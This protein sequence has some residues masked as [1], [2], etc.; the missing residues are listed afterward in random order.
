MERTEG[1]RENRT[2]PKPRGVD[3]V[4]DKAQLLAGRYGT[5]EMCDIWGP[6]KTFE[7]ALYVK[8]I[9]ATVL[10]EMHPDIIPPEHAREIA[11]AAN[12]SAVSADRIREIEEK[13]GHDVIAINK[14]L[15]EAV[16]PEAAAHINKAMTSADTTEPAKALQLKRSL[17]VL[18]DSTENLRDVILEKSQEWSM[19]PHMDTSH[20][21]DALPTTAGR[22]LA[23]YAE[24]LHSDIERMAYAH[25]NSTVGKWGDA[26]GN[27]HSA[28]LLGVDGLELQRRFCERLGINHMT[29]PAQIPAREFITDVVFAVTRTAGTLANIA[30]H[31]RIYRG[32]DAGM[33]RVPLGKK[34]SSAMP[35]KDA[36]GGNPSTEEQAVG[37]F[38]YCKGV[39]TTSVDTIS[40]NYARD[41]RGSAVDRITLEGMFK[42]TD[43]NIRNMAGVIHSL[44]IDEA[45]SRERFE[46]TYG[47]TA[48]QKVMTYLTDP[49]KLGDKA[50][51]REQAH[52]LTGKLATTAYLNKTPFIEMCL[53][54]P[55]IMSRIDEPILKELTSVHTYTGESQRI[56]S[57]VYGRLH[58][59]KKFG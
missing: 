54:A 50:M 59:Q 16:T 4:N 36:K 19:L 57:D 45:R 21:Y 51:T 1:R 42:F 23:H 34:G 37:C 2:E 48:A 56:I 28:N 44:M 47:V 12:L 55:D 25:A 27:H 33:F 43:H 18:V 40:M 9:A 7:F 8:G 35:H 3:P 58:G 15:A 32:D 14:A 11:E 38:S 49:R 5:K 46:R 31:I 30:D 26:T 53:G 17:E 13:T 10:S 6:E 29:A 22:P 24:T 41:L 20:L 52:E 39:L